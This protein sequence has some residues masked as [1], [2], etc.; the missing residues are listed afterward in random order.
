MDKVYNSRNIAIKFV[1]NN[2]LNNIITIIKKFKIKNINLLDAGCGE[3][4][5]L[6]KLYKIEKNNNYY[7]IDIVNHAINQTKKRCP[8][9]NIKLGDI[10]KTKYPNKFFDIIICTEVLEHIFEFKSVLKELRRILKPNGL[11]IITFPNEFLW[12]ISRLFLCRKSIR[13]PDHVNSFSPKFFKKN[14][15]MQLVFKRSLPFRLPFFISLGCLI[16]FKK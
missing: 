8:F 2:R 12:T 1:H 13:V 11:L 10:Y 6:E 7:G 15:N 14:V 9:A 5:L 4:H 3:G 16:I